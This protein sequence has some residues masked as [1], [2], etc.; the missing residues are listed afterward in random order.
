MKT[1]A[2]R[3]FVGNLRAVA[4]RIYRLS[5][6]P[7]HDPEVRRVFDFDGRAS[8]H[9]VHVVMQ[10]ALR[11][12]GDD[13]LYAFFLSGKYWDV[14]T[15]YV[16]PRTDGPRADKALL[17][18][19]GLRVEQ[20]FV[21]VYDFG[22][23][24]RHSLTVVSI[25]ESSAPLVAPLLVESVGEPPIYEKLWD[26]S[27]GESEAEPAPDAQLA[28]LIPLAE[29]FFEHSD[30]LGELGDDDVA[31]LE[32]SPEAAKALLR[33]LADAA[34][35]LASAVH[36]DLRLLLRLGDWFSDDELILHLL[37]LPAELAQVGDFEQALRVAEAQ[38]FISP[39]EVACDIAEIH[40][41]AGRREEALALVA[42][43]LERAIE[44]YIAETGAGDVYRALGEPDAAEAY[45]RRA[46]AEAKTPALRNE[47]ILRITSLLAD[48]GREADAAAFLEEQRPK[49]AR[50]PRGSSGGASPQFAAVGRNDPCPCGSG[51][52]SKK[53]HGA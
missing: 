32:A 31:P 13:H 29:A 48:H 53:C 18:R 21:Y 2:V 41:L 36:E 37:E 38:R 35:V 19:L 6:S 17:F 33:Q 49:A 10:H 25:T 14:K 7:D 28:P 22:D 5:I 44:P 42:Q 4:H 16:D 45:Y 9:D 26:E 34:L 46:L 3:T 8:L 43:N 51:K 12:G 27:E 1:L 47:A 40:A 52:K 20:C 39:E 50:S 24:L 15:E 30:A 11:L 23:E